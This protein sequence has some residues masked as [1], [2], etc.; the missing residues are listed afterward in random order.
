[1]LSYYSAYCQDTTASDIQVDFRV[2]KEWKKT[3]DTIF[4][5][6]DFKKTLNYWYKNISEGHQPLWTDPRRVDKEKR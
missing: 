1:M 2:P 6:K 5:L 3:S 4:V